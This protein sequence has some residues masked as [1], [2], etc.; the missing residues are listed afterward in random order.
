M[1]FYV[2]KGDLY[3]AG[4]ANGD[5]GSNSW[6]SASEANVLGKMVWPTSSAASAAISVGEPGCAPGGTVVEE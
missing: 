5:T 4:G 6:L 2:K 3:W 1:P